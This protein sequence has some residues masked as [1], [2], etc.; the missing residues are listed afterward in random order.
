M[1]AC[2]DRLLVF[3]V[4]GAA[5]LA[6]RSD[7]ELRDVFGVELKGVRARLMRDIEHERSN[8]TS[9]DNMA[10]MDIRLRQ[11]CY[12]LFA[13]VAMGFMLIELSQI[14]IPVILAFAL[15]VRTGK[16]L[17]FTS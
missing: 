15:T 14:I 2:S 13:S 9:T 10:T 11:F 4:N 6:I 7:R 12:I 17:Y 3:T 16:F 8:Q 1:K 5:L